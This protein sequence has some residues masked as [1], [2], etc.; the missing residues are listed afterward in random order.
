MTNTSENSWPTKREAFE[1]GVTFGRLLA[2]HQ[3]QKPPTSGLTKMTWWGMAEI[4]KNLI[5]YFAAAHK[6]VLLWRAIL[7]GS[8]GRDFLRWLGWL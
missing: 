1:L 8:I 3:M 2:T 6:L 4:I 7:L 5:G